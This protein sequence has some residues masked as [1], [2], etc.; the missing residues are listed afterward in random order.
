MADR[1][2]L[3]T[4]RAAEFEAFAAD[5][6]DVSKIDVYSQNDARPVESK[7]DG[8]GSGEAFQKSVDITKGQE[9]PWGDQPLS[10]AE[11][12]ALHDADVKGRNKDTNIP[13][14]RTAFQQSIRN[15]R[16]LDDRAAKCLVASERMLPGASAMM[17]EA[18]AMDLM[19]LPASSIDS[20]LSR[21][22]ALAQDVVKIAEEAAAKIEDKEAGTLP[23]ALQA[24]ID[25][26]KDGKP[27]ENVE[28]KEAGF[29]APTAP[30]AAPAAI[31]PADADKDADKDASEDKFAALEATVNSLADKMA[32]FFDKMQ[33]AKGD[34]PADEPKAEDA[35]AEAGQNAPDAFAGLP[36]K[37]A[38]SH[39]ADVLDSIF[40]AAVPA[41]KSGAAQ[42][43]G[44]VRKASDSSE[45]D[46]TALW[47]STP[48]VSAV[49]S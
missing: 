8:N 36:G 28:D 15:A 3:T 32:N 4:K 33:A 29:P 35:T 22:A 47:G 10:E 38:S 30:D 6:T 21:Q 44:M 20:I 46:L 25:A 5:T 27:E 41:K 43:S 34:K 24:A 23:P 16:E 1:V 2:R 37:T 42:L 12:K 13:E 18:N 7:R 45:G 14:I 9:Y 26:K 31:K 17:H 40:S 11:T 48:D 49:F 19:F 39:D